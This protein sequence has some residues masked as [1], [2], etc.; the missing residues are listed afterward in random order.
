MARSPRCGRFLQR[1]ERGGPVL[2]D[3]V[4]G[5]REGHRG[6]C[7]SEAAWRR[8]L[9]ANARGV[10]AYRSRAAAREDRDAAA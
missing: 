8:K 6:H 10:R 4:C 9:A 7:L 2:E 5:R 1:N 3:P